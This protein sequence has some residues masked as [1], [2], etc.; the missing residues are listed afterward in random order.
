M[1]QTEWHRHILNKFGHPFPP[2]STL[3]KFCSRPYGEHAG[4]TCPPNESYR[5]WED[6]RRETLKEVGELLTREMDAA[7]RNNKL[8]VIENCIA[9]LLKGK[10][11]G[12]PQADCHIE[13]V[14]K[15]LYT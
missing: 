3:C 7:E 6:A 9:Q 10:M 14:P 4:I 12:L 13:D 1:E 5:V 2:D 15:H 8:A 11:P